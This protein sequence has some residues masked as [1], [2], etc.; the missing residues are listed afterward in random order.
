MKQLV[1]GN[2]GRGLNRVPGEYDPRFIFTLTF[3]GMT[4]SILLTEDAE[5]TPAGSVRVLLTHSRPFF[6]KRLVP[7]GS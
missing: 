5:D 7:H 4:L 6:N 2:A 1:R 3:R